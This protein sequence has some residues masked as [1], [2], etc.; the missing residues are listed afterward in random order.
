MTAG[1]DCRRPAPVGDGQ[2]RSAMASGARGQ[3]DAADDARDNGAPVSD[4]GMPFRLVA[5]GGP[6]DSL[7]S[8]GD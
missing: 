3:R 1:P 2:L 7:F 4:Y 5:N 8:R 6:T